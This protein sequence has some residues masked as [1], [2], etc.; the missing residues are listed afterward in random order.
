MDYEYY[1]KIKHAFIWIIQ[2]KNYEKYITKITNNINI[3]ANNK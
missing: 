2:S 3:N 1:S